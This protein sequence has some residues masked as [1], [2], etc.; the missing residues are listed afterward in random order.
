MNKINEEAKLAVKLYIYSSSP[1]ENKAVLDAAKLKSLSRSI[2][3]IDT[4]AR[5]RELSNREVARNVIL[6]Q[7]VQDILKTYGL[8]HSRNL[9]PRGYA[10]YIH[11]PDGSYN[12]LG[13]SESGWGI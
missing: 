1:S 12:T 3:R 5:N 13:G 7:A 8:K 9:D 10:V 4:A 2:G 11:F 6:N